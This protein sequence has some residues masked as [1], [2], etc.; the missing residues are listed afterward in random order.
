[1][2][3]SHNGVEITAENAFNGLISL[4]SLSLDHNRI[5]AV[6]VS[7]ESVKNLKDLALNNNMLT[8]VPEFIGKAGRLRTLDLG[9]NAISKIDSDSFAN[10]TDLYGLRLA[11][12]RLHRV[13]N[14]TFVNCPNIHVLNLAHNFI[15]SVD[16]FAFNPL[17]ELRAL[18]LDNNKLEDLNGLVSSL[19][20][21]QWLN[22]SSNEL[23]WFDYAFVPSSLEWLDVSANKLAELGNF[24]EL[25]NFG[26]RSLDASGNSIRG[27]N[28]KSFPGSLAKIALKENLIEKVEPLTFAHLG[29]LAEVDLSDNKISSL[30]QDA[31]RV[32]SAKGNC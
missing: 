30:L 9:N 1:M 17:Q 18:R 20:N 5:S 13:A 14:E 28:S 7:G 8:F 16:Q 31:L 3:L 23:Q 24:Y 11:Q 27:L 19:A 12:N 25:D 15:S 6:N 26:L 4:E 22:V 2:A 29:K 21:L 32:S 10:L